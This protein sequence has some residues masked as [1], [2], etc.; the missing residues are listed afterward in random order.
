MAIVE[1]RPPSLDHYLDGR[2]AVFLAGPIQGAPDWQEQAIQIFAHEYTRF[3]ALNIFNPRFGKVSSH[4]Y[5]QQVLWEKRQ[6]E[7]ARDHGAILF[8]FAAKDGS[9][10]YE[11]GRAYAQTSR[12]ELGRAFGWRDYNGG[13]KIVIGIEP[14]YRGSE[15]Y[16][17]TLADEYDMPIYENLGGLCLAATGL[18]NDQS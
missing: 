5:A 10:P 18:L 6:L 13:V 11:E 7:R 8:W 16:F 12:V 9:L 1:H 4:N 3:P 15:K 2:P 17:K 14:G